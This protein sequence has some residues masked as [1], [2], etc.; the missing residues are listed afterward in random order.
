MPSAL[1]P[2]RPSLHRSAQP[3]AACQAAKMAP[4]KSLA[5]PRLAA[6]QHACA[7]GAKATA[8]QA[9]R[10]E[11][12]HAICP[13]GR[14][15]ARF[16]WPLALAGLVGAID[17]MGQADAGPGRRLAW[18]RAFEKKRGSGGVGCGMLIG[19]VCLMVELIAAR[20]RTRTELAAGRREL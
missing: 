7:G 5:D 1:P 19:K 11:Q 13:I 4:G 14:E 17:A 6:D 16:P 20:S 3:R 12:R 2:P 9:A 18:V 8:E 10:R 15:A